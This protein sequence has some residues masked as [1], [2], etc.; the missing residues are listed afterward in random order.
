MSECTRINDELVALYPKLVGLYGFLPNLFYM[1]STLPRLIMAQ[2]GLLD[3]IVICDGALPRSQK[4]NILRTV[5]AAW[6][7]DYYRT[8]AGRAPDQA[9]DDAVL[10]QFAHK[11]A[12][13]SPSFS[14]ND[15]DRLKKSGFASEAVL[16]SIVTT[17]LGQLLCTLA[18][19]LHPGLDPGLTRIRGNAPTLDVRTLEFVEN[20]EPSFENQPALPNDSPPYVFFRNQ[21]GF[22]PNAF[23]CQSSRPAL[24]EAEAY[25]LEQILVPE[26]HLSCIQKGNIFLVVSAANLNS[27]WL[28]LWCQMLETLGEPADISDQ[29]VED[30]GSSN[31]SSADKRLLDETRK[32]AT[33]TVSGER[34]FGREE[35]GRLGFTEG[36]IVEAIAV[37]ALAN[38]FNTLQAGVGATPDFPPRR[39]FTPKDLYS[40]SDQSR[41]TSQASPIDPDSELVARVQKGEMDAFEGLVRRHTRRVFGVLAGIVGNMDEVRD[42]TQ[43]VFL[44]AFEHIERFQ[45]RSK[46]STWLTSIAINTGTELLR[47]RRPTESLAE[48]ED[49]E[50]FRP[51][52]VQSWE[53]DPEQLLAASQ[54]SQ[55]VREAILRL[56]QKYRIAVLLRDINQLSTEDAAA[57]LG[58]GVP[59][60]KAR[61]LRGRLMLRESLA[62]HFTRAEKRS[63]DA[64]LR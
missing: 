40:R 11:L 31:L 59:A 54:R 56:P 3:A 13:C 57:A 50:G 15:I 44:K 29:I 26:D 33:L 8:L 9:E 20:R 43:D 46:F 4:E 49:D 37:A 45:G 12:K 19:G 47:Q 5:A 64:E 36:Q 24:L 6:P 62:P 42:V 2:E 10:R 21:F 22:V 23:K 41:L 14:G 16:E 7:D 60:L 55:L 61:V 53:E 18:E 48:E 58:I 51:R 39:I 35:L 27:Y 38:F 28:A 63:P 17:A 1:Q 34:P 25:A 32:L 52:Q 30:S